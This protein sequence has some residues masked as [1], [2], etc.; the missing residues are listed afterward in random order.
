MPPALV[1][2]F[3][4]C[5]WLAFFRVR[6]METDRCHRARNRRTRKKRGPRRDF[7]G[8]S[9]RADLTGTSPHSQ[10]DRICNDR[11]SLPVLR[12]V[13]YREDG[14]KYRELRSV[15]VLQAHPA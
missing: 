9:R 4:R 1:R 13:V 2:L 6:E 11:G 14:N 10:P 3:V 5:S 12:N 7:T 15:T 8:T